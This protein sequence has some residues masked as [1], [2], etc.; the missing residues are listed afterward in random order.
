MAKK[1][2]V[3]RAKRFGKRFKRRPNVGQMVTRGIGNM[4][5]SQAAYG[6]MKGVGMLR[7]IINSELK[8]FDVAVSG[9]AMSTTAAFIQ[10][11]NIAEGSD[12]ADRT[13][14]SILAKYL[15]FKYYVT[16]NPS[17]GGSE[18]RIL[19]F[20]DT[21]NQGTNPVVADIITGAGN[22]ITSPIN[23]DNTQRFTTL[24]DDR[25]SL[26]INGNRTTARKHYIPLNFHIRY[27]GSAGSTFNKNMIYLMVV[28]NEATNTP[29]LIGDA[30]LAYYDN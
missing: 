24:F 22:A 27:Q 14:N 20:V 21:Q 29:T 13:G 18:A 11:A 4:T 12:V 2:F 19:C 6:A 25:I 1:S 3:K 10:L 7:G 9:T 16:I 8:R 30:R 5:L 26:S 17:A 28:S 15:T 23:A